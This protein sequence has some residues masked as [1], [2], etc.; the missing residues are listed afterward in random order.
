MS[1]AAEGAG[2]PP[3]RADRRD[4]GVPSP[5][6]RCPPARPLSLRARLERNRQSSA[7]SREICENTIVSLTWIAEHLAIPP[8]ERSQK[9]PAD[10]PLTSFR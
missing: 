5:W 2:A 4:E 10:N 7:P 6:L 8:D 3:P 1:S 9:L